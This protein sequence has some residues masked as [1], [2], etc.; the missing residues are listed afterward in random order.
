MAST[1]VVLPWS[2]CAM[3]AILRML[4][5]KRNPSQL[6]ISYYFTT[7]GGLKGLSARRCDKYLIHCAASARIEKEWWL[8]SRVI[9]AKD[10]GVRR[11]NSAFLEYVPVFNHESDIHLAF[12]V[13]RGDGE[14]QGIARGGWC[15]GHSV[16]GP[17][18]G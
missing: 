3:M 15:H 14:K 16:D 10:G 2:T 17:R 1:R 4:E 11:I 9:S 8:G 13:C 7:R 6:V 12:L 5:L 18:T